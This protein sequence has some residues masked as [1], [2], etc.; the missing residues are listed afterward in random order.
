MCP[1]W[2]RCYVLT[3]LV[4][5][6]SL[7]V[8]FGAE[9]TVR[10]SKNYSTDS[11]FLRWQDCQRIAF[12]EG[13][14]NRDLASGQCLTFQ[15][16][17]KQGEFANLVITQHGIDVAAS[18]LGQSGDRLGDMD[19]PN[20]LQ[21]E[22]SVSI[23][24]PSDSD[25]IVEIRSYDKWGPSGSIEIALS[26]LRKATA[27]D[28][29]R[30][31]AEHTFM[32]GQ[33][34]R[35]KATIE[36][37]RIAVTKYLEALNLWKQL[38]DRRGQAYALCSL[39]KV[40]KDLGLF[41]QSLD[42]FDQ[43]LSILHSTKDLAEQAY[44][45]NEVGGVY[46]GLG[47][48]GKALGY[49]DRVLAL[50]RTIEDEWGEAQALN[51]IGLVHAFAGN[52]GQ[53]VEY[54]NRA[55]ALWQRKGDRG[56]EANTRN[57]LAG[58]LDE[59]GQGKAA[60]DM[61]ESV[62]RF[63]QE[64]GNRS[65]EAFVQNNIGKIYDTWAE[66]QKALDH[67]LTAVKLYKDTNNLNGW[68]TALDNIG[69]HYEELADPSRALDFL[70]E[71]LEIRHKGPGGPRGEANTLSNI[72]Y[73]YSLLGNQEKALQY[74][75]QSLYLLQQARDSR[76]E[77][78]ILITRGISY[79]ALR[80][81]EAA[82]ADYRRAA[83]LHKESADTRGQAFALEKAGE[84]YQSLGRPKE[85]L[86]QFP[87]ALELFRT[88][89]ERQG[90]AQTL[91]AMSRAEFDSG[92]PNRSQQDVEQAIQIIESLRVKTASQQLRANFFSSKQDFY[93]LDIQVEMA[94]HKAHPE[95]GFGAA[96]LYTSEKARARVLLDR[97]GEGQLD[98]AQ[99]S[100]ALLERKRDIERQ[101]STTAER[102]LL[103][104]SDPR[105]SEDA[106]VL[107][108][109]VD[110]LTREYDDV[111]ARIRAE[112]K[113]YK[114][115][116]ESRLVSLKDIQSQLLDKET[117]LLEYSLG[118][119]QSFLWLV[120]GDA[121][122]RS[123]ELPG[124]AV[125]EK[126]ALDFRETVTA[127]QAHPSEDAE[128]HMARV[129]KADARY[130]V[131]AAE[132]G[133]MV[134]GPASS[135][136]QDKRLVI[137]ADGVLQLIP[138]EAL[139]IGDAAAA[140][141]YSRAPHGNL[142]GSPLVQNH[143]IVYEPSA[144]VVA[145]LRSQPPRTAP[146]STVI[147]ADPVFDAQD[148]RVS[149]QLSAQNAGPSQVVKR[150]DMDQALR[151]A[152]AAGSRLE[153][154]LSSREEASEIAAMSPPGS[155]FLALDFQANKGAFRKEDL[156]QYR[157]IHFATHGVMDDVH[158]ELSGIILSLV[159]EH[160][161]A[162]EGFLRLGDIYALNL[163][164]DLVVLSACRTGLGKEIK[165]EGMLSLTRAFLYAGSARV[166]ASLWKVDDEVT[167]E[168]MK[169]FYRGMLKERLSPVGALRQAKIQI[170][171]RQRWKSPFYWAGFVIQGDWK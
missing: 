150:G 69:V 31:A 84:A 70:N 108:K 133:R 104:R 170:Q 137:V 20:G 54:Y 15:I 154:L 64:T 32:E 148:T 25:Y 149:G 66:S 160:G 38:T 171:K 109:Q 33:Q 83:D 95:Q 161:W 91:Y 26:V 117:V 12:G 116:T 3:V 131:Q 18:I 28:Q 9:S 143:E 110:S 27:D 19:S 24:A 80:K 59:L 155:T 57:G 53:A 21:G 126:A 120:A 97:L 74:Y 139:I 77:A 166:V 152:G 151:D 1:E 6:L 147:F 58:A 68:A 136:L 44:V 121:P 123:F 112:N 78:Y 90:E 132:L 37:R 72:G 17:L 48:Y 167:A 119:Q 159:D 23:I 93:R 35:G 60:L 43:A 73:S 114:D 106:T 127:R 115:L 34:A 162:Q 40:S 92:S 10:G 45:L 71:S 165:G 2:R 124:R 101:L 81:F 156:S 153:R 47:N 50:R 51:N 164:A 88:V 113:A 63:C 157:I 52:F 141:K 49:Y 4:L 163:R 138:F 82:L 111:E 5:S 103:A 11:K 122:L 7:R 76:S 134:L 75:A 169:A 99:A 41:Q 79:S 29:K 96:A 42:Y 86:E 142:M 125:I 145:M 62:L 87:K 130:L 85:A 13:P 61:F 158:P 146:K 55:L 46:R 102:S 8:E 94:L 16:S 118:E 22:E 36:S 135:F 168:L 107:V 128:S 100:P 65:L 140:A 39:G 98:L 30:V 14:C 105:R 144:S 129:R 89:G 67:Y 56:Q